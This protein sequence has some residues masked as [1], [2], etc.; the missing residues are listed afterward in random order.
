M[1]VGGWGTFF[2]NHDCFVSL[3][4]AGVKCGMMEAVFSS[5]ILD[6]GGGVSNGYR[7]CRELECTLNVVSL[8]ELGSNVADVCNH[9]HLGAFLTF[10]REHVDTT[11]AS[12]SPSL[13]FQL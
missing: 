9:I 10:L 8:N 11:A 12:F 2:K 7:T 6:R 3:E 4:G 1:G 13:C 5:C